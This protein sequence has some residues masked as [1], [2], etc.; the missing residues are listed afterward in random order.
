MLICLHVPPPY[1]PPP[2]V[3]SIN[4]DIFS[5]RSVE[6][7]CKH[8]SLSALQYLLFAYWIIYSDCMYQGFVDDLT[9]IFRYSETEYFIKYCRV[10]KII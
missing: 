5:G 10:G 9:I 4:I 3:L 2:G 6:V 1:P 7:L 8:S